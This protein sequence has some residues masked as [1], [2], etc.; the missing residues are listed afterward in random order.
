MVSYGKILLRIDYGWRVIDLQI[1]ETG[2][3][4]HHTAEEITE[5]PYQMVRL[6][7]GRA[8]EIFDLQKVV[9]EAQDDP[10]KFVPDPIESFQEVM[11]V[12]GKGF[13]LGVFVENQLIAVRTVSF[14]GDTQGNMGREIG[15]TEKRDLEKVA[16]LEATMVRPDYR[17]NA[18]QKKML[19]HTMKMIENYGY[20]YV[21]CTVSPFNY[22]SLSSVMFAGLYIKDLRL[23]TGVY[24]GKL[25]FLLAKGI[26][27]QESLSFGD[28]LVLKN[29]EI[30]KQKLLLEIGG[31]GFKLEEIQEEPD[32]FMVSYGFPETRT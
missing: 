17:G 32:Q 31:V 24:G 21:L 2:L 5:K 3:L 25:R 11:L 8:Q 6:D 18:L 7:P 28:V 26:C 4:Y 20:G 16:I 22:P 10:Q 15:L 9:Y 30:K 29:T 19:V 14:P 13:S 27:R 23:R 1:I 12:E